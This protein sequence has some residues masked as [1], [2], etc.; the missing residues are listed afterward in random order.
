MCQ[1]ELSRL[2]RIIEFEK[3]LRGCNHEE[4]TSDLD[5][6]LPAKE[7]RIEMDEEFSPLFEQAKPLLQQMMD[8]LKK[9]LPGALSNLANSPVN[10]RFGSKSLITATTYA[11]NHIQWAMEAQFPPLNKLPWI[12]LPQE[13]TD[14][15]LVEDV[16]ILGLPEADLMIFE[17]GEIQPDDEPIINEPINIDIPEEAPNAATAETPM[18]EVEV[19]SDEEFKGKILR[20]AIS[21]QNKAYEDLHPEQRAG[22]ADQP[23]LNPSK[24]EKVPFSLRKGQP[25][26]RREA[27]RDPVVYNRYYC[28]PFHIEPTLPSTLDPLEDANGPVTTT[29]M[30]HPTIGH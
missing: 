25:K 14:E 4:S 30:S 18:V 26:W 21:E 1:P 19:D 7:V 12:D 24:M 17:P 15:D 29:C 2:L 20:P 9:D 11:C 3:G 6:H 5:I 22:W 28:A 27:M 13:V 16:S 8:M 23:F 10:S